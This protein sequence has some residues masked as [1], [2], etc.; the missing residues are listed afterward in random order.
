MLKKA[1]IVKFPGVFDEQVYNE[2]VSRSGCFLGNSTLEQM[3]NQVKLSNAVVGVAGAGGIGGAVALGLARLGVRHIKIADPDSFD[4]SNINRQF[5]ASVETVGRNKALVVAELVHR[6]AGDV[7]VDVFPEGIQKHTAEAFVEDCD[8]VLDQMDFYSIAERYA[9][10]RAY[11]HSARCKG[12]L[13]SS[14]V[15][16]GANIYKFDKAGLTLEDFYDIPEEAQMTPELVE[17]LVML[18]A[19]YQP[20]FPSIPDIFSWMKETGNV[21]ILSVA[22]TASHYLILCRSALML[23]D[24]EGAPYST[25]LPPM[26]KY[27]WFDGSTF[28][29]GI[30]EFDGTWA[31]PEEHRKHFNVN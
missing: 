20:R 30:Y 31:N 14:V 2:R 3:A 28:D 10:H 27:Y 13:A 23:C 29:N 9:L 25:E 4:I 8:L 12:L 5:G 26:P 1:R 24:L 6:L 15:G 7:S 22:P 17:R 18:Q 21:P 16:W 11:R 19:S